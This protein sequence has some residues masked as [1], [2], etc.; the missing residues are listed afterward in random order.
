MGASGW[1]RTSGLGLDM[2]S[3]VAVTVESQP[4]LRALTN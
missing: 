1:T 2:T 4:A 3:K